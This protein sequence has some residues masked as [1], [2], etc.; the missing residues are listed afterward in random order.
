MIL[1]SLES[2]LEEGAIAEIEFYKKKIV[3]FERPK[4][5]INKFFTGETVDRSE[6]TEKIRRYINSRREEVRILG[7][8]SDSPPKHDIPIFVRKGSN[9]IEKV[10][11]EHPLSLEQEQVLNLLMEL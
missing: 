1:E 3:L 2:L 5:Y 10:S 9:R 11:S 8:V 6:L 4:L 7:V